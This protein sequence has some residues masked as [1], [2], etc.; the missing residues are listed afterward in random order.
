MV[1]SKSKVVTRTGAALT[2]AAI[3]VPLMSAIAAGPATATRA[4]SITASPATRPCTRAGRPTRRPPTATPWTPAAVHGDHGPALR[5]AV[6]LRPHPQQVHPLAG[7]VRELERPATYTIHVRNSVKWSNGS[8]LTGADVAYSINLAKANP[9]VPYS[10]MASTSGR[11]RPPAATRSR[12]TSPAPPRTPPGRTTCGT[13][14]YCPR[15][16]GR[17]VRHRSGHGRQHQ[18][19]QQRAD[20]AVPAGTTRPKPATRTTPTGGAPPSWASRSTSST[21]AT[22]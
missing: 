22:R 8:S 4:P 17:A 9:A 7:H 14:P 16:P 20:D 13:S 6:P 18:P 2:A 10:N 5:D 11:A 21:S 12:S 1:I 19:R 15:A 3:V